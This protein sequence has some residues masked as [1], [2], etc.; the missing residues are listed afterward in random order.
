MRWEKV[1]GGRRWEAVPVHCWS[2]EGQIGPGSAPSTARNLVTEL[3]GLRQ[4]NLF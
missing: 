2:V 4:T 3:R 1:E